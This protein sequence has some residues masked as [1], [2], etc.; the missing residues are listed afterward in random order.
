MYFVS[1][2]TK[3][4]RSKNNENVVESETR[5]G[6][7]GCYNAVLRLSDRIEQNVYQS[8]RQGYKR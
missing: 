1:A 4:K 8:Y 3:V 6:N 5:G 2:V 7:L